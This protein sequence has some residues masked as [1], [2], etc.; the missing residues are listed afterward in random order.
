MEMTVLMKDCG[1]T[2]LEKQQ[3]VVN[4]QLDAKLKG[5][6][7]QP[8]KNIARYLVTFIRLLLWPGDYDPR[9]VSLWR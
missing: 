7:G 8:S 1:A 9:C 4:P 2:S 6:G 3:K 5:R